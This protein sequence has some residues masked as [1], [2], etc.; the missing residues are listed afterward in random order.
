MHASLIKSLYNFDYSLVRASKRAALCGD[1]NCLLFRYIYI[2]IYIYIFIY[3]Y[4][5]VPSTFVY[6]MQFVQFAL[7]F[8]AI[9][10]TLGSERTGA[11]S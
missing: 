7:K 9:V 8:V 11:P 3:I 5:Y 4:I 10:P 1:S 6:F 2:Y